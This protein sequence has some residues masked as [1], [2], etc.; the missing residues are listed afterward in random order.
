MSDLLIVT[1]WCFKLNLVPS[2][3]HRRYY[4]RKKKRILPLILLF[5]QANETRCDQ[6]KMGRR[7][8]QSGYA[9]GNTAGV[10]TISEINSRNIC[11][12]F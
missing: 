11:F 9:I 12:S 10:F 3:H 5:M 1:V 6:F 2:K 8:P 7:A 4:F